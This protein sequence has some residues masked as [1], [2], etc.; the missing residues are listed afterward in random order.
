MGKIAAL[1]SHGFHT[2][3]ATTM[4]RE[5]IELT[6]QTRPRV[7]L[8]PLASGDDSLYI[9]TFEQLYRDILGCEVDVLLLRGALQPPAN[10]KDLIDR[11][12]LIFF[13]GGE[14]VSAIAQIKRLGVADWIASACNRGTVAAGEG[15][16]ARFLF[17]GGYALSMWGIGIET[18]I[19]VTLQGIGL[20]RGLLCTGGENELTVEGFA[21]SMLG[22][23]NTGFMLSSG[24]G[25]FIQDRT[26]YNR[27][28]NGQPGFSRVVANDA[29]AD[30]VNVFS[31]TPRPLSSLYDGEL[32]EV[33]LEG[34]AQNRH[35]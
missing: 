17:E 35:R 11:A 19:I 14:N 29:F 1:G 22:N 34:Y 27:V 23:L 33:A 20:V 28:Y 8:I 30:F 21:A 31:E 6:G 32:G 9:R 7:L 5:V 13:G 25:L 15:L 10:A 18:P 2:T 24:C 16:G 12:S 26:Y 4:H 3:Y